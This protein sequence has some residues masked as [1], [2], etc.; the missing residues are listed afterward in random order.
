VVT[1]S[2]AAA[3]LALAGCE[4]SQ[5]RPSI[6]EAGD[7]AAVR[8][9]DVPPPPPEPTHVR[10]TD[11]AAALGLVYGWPEQPRPMRQIEAFG[12]GC[13]FFDYDQ[14][15]WQD[16]LFVGDPHV[17]LFRNCQGRSFRNVTATSGLTVPTGDW[18]GCGVADADGDGWLDL[19]I[20]G[21]HQLAYFRGTGDGHFVEVT[22]QAGFDPG[23]RGHWGSSAGFMDLDGDLD[24][25]LVLLNYVI[26]GP[27][28]QQYCEPAPGVRSG[29]SPSVYSPEFGEIW[30]NEGNGTFTLIPHENGMAS[31]NGKGLVVSFA[32]LDDDGLKDFYI[33][34][35]GTP[36]ELMHNLGNMQ[37]ENLG[38]L[39]GVARDNLETLAA[40]GSDF[41]DYDRDGDLDLCVTGFSKQSYAIFQCEG[42]LFFSTVADR[43]GIALPTYLPLGFGAKWMDM[44]ND[45]WPDVTFAN[46]HVYERTEEFDI[47]TTFRQ[48]VM[49][50][51]S[52]EGKT[53]RDLTPVLGG[54][55]A[56]LLVARGSAT[57]DFDNDGRMDLLVVDYEGPAM[58]L[59]NRTETA[60][61][62]IKLDL[63][64]GPPNPYAYGAK[65]TARAGDDVWV[66][67]VSPAS[68]YL[69][70]SDPRIHFGLGPVDRL[71]EI[72]VRWP[73]GAVETVR[74]VAADQ[75]VTLREGAGIVETRPP[76]PTAPVPAA[77]P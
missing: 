75:I 72:T 44:D 38:V 29:C 19:F 4:S 2:L 62:W 14:D 56:R 73:S 28:V 53:F 48:P 57:G 41:A 68:S 8:P 39:S 65:V 69:S 33:G 15:G 10:F 60:N 26:F 7:P 36:A 47:G 70:S 76:S 27:Q 55:V 50:F 16:V 61:H 18:C 42:G 21:Y 20:T 46:G 37:F 6:R 40:M 9:A 54:D 77:S 5:G 25:G 58:L 24:L 45:A 12:S 52:R 22:S 30:R 23:N 35:D 67:E 64:S 32:D 1:A 17:S 63:R 31:T 34:N 3:A 51:H 59:H 74:D 13:V 43:L 66:Q 49:L 11:D 71:E